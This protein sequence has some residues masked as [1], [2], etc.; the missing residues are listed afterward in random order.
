MNGNRTISRPILKFAAK[1]K[2]RPSGRWNFFMR[3]IKFFLTAQIWNISRFF[4]RKLE[5]WKI[6]GLEFSDFASICRK[7][8]FFGIFPAVCETKFAK[9]MHIYIKWYSRSPPAPLPVFISNFVDRDRKCIASVFG[10]LWIL[11]K[12]LD[13]K[14]IP[15]SAYIM[16]TLPLHGLH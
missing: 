5:F 11:D 15:A 16:Y 10:L 13:C 14:Y 12:H 2:V 6:F 3:S 7:K 9:A 1:I 4:L 8:F